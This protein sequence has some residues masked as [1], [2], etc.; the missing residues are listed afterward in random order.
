MCI[1]GGS[2]LFDRVWWQVMAGVIVW[3]AFAVEHLC[4]LAGLIGWSL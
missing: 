3:V 1:I 2:C 4:R